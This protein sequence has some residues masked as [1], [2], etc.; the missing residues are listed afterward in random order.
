MTKKKLQILFP[1][2]YFTKKEVDSSYKKEYEATKLLGIDSLLFN[3]DTLICDGKLSISGALSND[4]SI[5]IYRGWMLKP[6]EYLILNLTFIEKFGISL[7]NNMG[8]YS[9]CH[10]FDKVYPIIKDDT[11]YIR[12]MFMDDL[13][14]EY[15]LLPKLFPN[16]FMM[17]DNVK[18]VKGTNFPMKISSD[19]TFDEFKN[20][21]YRFIEER[22]ILYTGQIILKDYVDLIRYGKDDSSFTNEFRAF[23]YKGNLIS[24]ERNSN[25]TFDTNK[26]PMNLVMK[27]SDKIK[28]NFYTLDFGELSNGKW[29]ILESGDGQVSGLSPNQNV[30]AFYSKINEVLNNTI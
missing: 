2:D 3:Y 27:Y 29:V 11:P 24:L 26:P 16:G 13:E 8:E 28:S 4:I 22:G 1:C 23:F 17:K 15:N 19:I 14:H 9:K 10:Y 21:V 18:S 25:Q 6:A 12:Q 5:L 30:I 20:L 7:I